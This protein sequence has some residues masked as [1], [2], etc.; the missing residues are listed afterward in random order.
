VNVRTQD[1]NSFDEC[2]NATLVRFISH[3]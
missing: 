2:D 3:K 1:A